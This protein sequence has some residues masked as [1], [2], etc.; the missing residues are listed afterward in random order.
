MDNNITRF[1]DQIFQIIERWNNK[2]ITLM[3]V[4][5]LLSESKNEISLIYK[6]QK[7]SI[8]D[9]HILEIV[10][11]FSGSLYYYIQAYHTEKTIR[12]YGFILSELI[13]VLFWSDQSILAFGSQYAYVF[14]CIDCIFVRLKLHKDN[15]AFL[16]Y[17]KDTQKYIIS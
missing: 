7:N 10:Q 16:R 17:V 3:K 9:C 1:D 14:S 4:E 11:P 8:Y 2:S 12:S 6:F 13:S 15:I 5:D